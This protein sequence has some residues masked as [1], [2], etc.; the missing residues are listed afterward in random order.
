MTSQS[1]GPK[2]SWLARNEPEV[3]AETSYFFMAHTFIAHRLTGEYVLDH[4]SASVC[5]PLY[6]TGQNR[7]IGDW[8]DEVAPGLKMPELRWP[9]EVTREA[10]QATGLPA[11]P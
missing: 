8:C 7:W 2:I 1:V 3:W 9:A 5:E 10:A 6:H 11:S 4:P